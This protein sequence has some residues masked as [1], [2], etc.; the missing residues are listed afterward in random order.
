M[1]KE[2]PQRDAEA[3]RRHLLEVAT[4]AFAEAGLDGV[5]VDQLAAVAGVN[6]RMIYHYFGDKRGLYEAVL[7]AAAI[8]VQ[9][10]GDLQALA[11]W[12]IDLCDRLS[13]DRARLLAW[14][15]LRLG[16]P[17]PESTASPDTSGGPGQQAQED[18]ALLFAAASVLPQLCPQLVSQVTGQEAE[19]PEFQQRWQRFSRRLVRM[20]ESASSAPKERV[21]LS[22]DAKPSVR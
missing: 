13:G 7:K 4:A 8:A 14:E 22:G 15:G 19:S 11:S 18:V 2:A 3:T 16:A 10:P 20:I 5:R 1:S 17:G 9:V 21:R 6:K 12:Q